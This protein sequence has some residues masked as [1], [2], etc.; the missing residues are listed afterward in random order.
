MQAAEALFEFKKTNRNLAPD[1]NN[2][3][4]WDKYGRFFV[5]HGVRGG[6]YFDKDLRSIR[7][8]SMF[9]DSLQ[10]IEKIPGMSQFSFRP[11]PDDLLDA[12]A[13][14][15]LKND[16]KKKYGKICREEEIQE[17]KMIQDKIREDK[18]VIRDEF[19][20]NFFLPLRRK[21]EE[22]IEQYEALW[23]LKDDEMEPE[24]HTFDHVYA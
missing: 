11:R 10:S 7:I 22:N 8:Y 24:L 18:K 21:Y 5:S 19:I 16:F 13:L 17:R 9:G 4:I 14:K 3:G 23:P 15:D 20:Y 12:K 1:N 2:R 6:S